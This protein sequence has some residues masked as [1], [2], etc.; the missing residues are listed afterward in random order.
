MASPD[1]HGGSGNSPAL[2]PEIVLGRRKLRHISVTAV[3][4]AAERVAAMASAR[5]R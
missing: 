4:P 5:V 2:G 3:N 1:Q